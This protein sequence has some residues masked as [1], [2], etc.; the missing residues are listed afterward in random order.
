MISWRDRCAIAIDWV[1]YAVRRSICRARGHR[2]VT[3][4]EDCG[5]RQTVT[6]GYYC[7]CCHKEEA[8]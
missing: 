2:W 3:L 4:T 5:A 6:V 1:E 8:L 7:K